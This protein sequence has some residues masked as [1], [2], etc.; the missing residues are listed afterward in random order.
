MQTRELG[1]SGLKVSALGLGC[2]GM[3]WAYGPGGERAEMIGL[4]RAAV[5][6][7]VNF[8]D[9]AEVYGPWVNEELVGEALEP[10]RE[11][12]VIATKF[13]FALD[14]TGARLGGVNS[15]PEHIRTVAH[16]SLRR[17]R[18]DH[19]DLFYQHRVDPAVPIEEVAGAV[20]QLIREGK[21]RHFGMSEAAVAT[22]RRAHAVQ[23]VAA[24][25]NEYSLWTR[26]PEHELLPALE[27]L[28]IGL[29]AYSPLGRGF[30]A[31]AFKADTRLQPG[32]FRM[33]IPRFQP[34]AL[35]SNAAL[36]EALTALAQRKHATAGQLALAWVL[37]QR[38]WIVAIP[39]TRKRTR[40]EE[41]LGGAEL[42]LTA[43]DLKAIDQLLQSHPVQEPR[44]AER[45][46]SMVNL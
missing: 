37:A 31:G 40:L 6:L 11:R 21:V 15:R 25:Q 4:I 27:A 45:E 41:N 13:G 28:G 29:V 23:K 24:V 2:M 7:G 38:P 26:Q 17:L 19:I 8:F 34:E 3:S 43:D 33:N 16:A 12:V 44:Y 9:T 14:S 42:V 46:M 30:L 39:G 22:I 18:T 36:V 32:D 20:G 5:D 10:L 35:Q 1:R